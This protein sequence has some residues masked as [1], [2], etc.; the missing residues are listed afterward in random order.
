MKFFIPSSANPSSLLSTIQ[1]VTSFYEK[2]LSGEEEYW[3][4]QFTGAVMFIKMMG[5]SKNQRE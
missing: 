1:Y 4:A 5:N 2:R 3:W